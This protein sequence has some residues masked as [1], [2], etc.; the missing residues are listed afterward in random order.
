MIDTEALRKKILDLAVRGKLVPQNPDDEPASVLLQKIA[1]EKKRLVKEGKIKKQKKLP[2]IMEEEIPFEIPESWEWVRFGEIFDIGSARRIHKTDWQ[3]EG[4]PFFRGR[5]L[6]KLIKTGEPQAEIFITRD[7]YE[8]NKEKGGVPQ[9][10]DLLVTAVG[11]IGKVYVVKGT[12]PFYYKDAYILRFNNFGKL[13]P[14]FFKYLIE[15]PFEQNFIKNGSMRTTV[16]QLT[17]IKA[18]RMLCPF[19]PLAEQKCIV[20]KI[21]ELLSQLDIIDDLQSQYSDNTSA[22]KQ[23]LLDVAIR[24]NLVPQDPA[25]EPAS[26][27]LKKIAEEKKKLVKEGKIKK[28]KKT[29]YIQKEGN[30]WFEYIGKSRTCID[31]EIP[32]EIPNNWAWVRLNE[33]GNYKKG[34]FGSALTKSMFVPKGPHSVKVYEQ[35]NAIQ[36]DWKLGSYYITDK[37]YHEKM[38]GFTV[39][40]GDVIVSCAGT[41]GETYIMPEDI[42]LGIINQAL[43]RMQIY[44]P[45]NVE[46]FLMYFDYSIKEYARQKSKGSAIKNIPPFAI[47][48]RILFPMPPLNE[49]KRILSKLS[50]LEAAVSRI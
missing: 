11:T 10:D 2:E 22:L 38:T 32:F 24:G 47:F 15:S 4:I 45:M 23:K 39:N 35:K 41:I 12:K 25:D 30:S 26:V 6:V 44:K 36:K 33:L 19:P 46:Y 42:E 21:D 31:D 13:Y 7:L 34:P 17:I 29:G 3:K 48:K 18:N 5:E 43:M 28:D 8:K 49:Q 1:E 50:E 14:L 37:Y 27:L 9:K 16:A 40:P 20:K